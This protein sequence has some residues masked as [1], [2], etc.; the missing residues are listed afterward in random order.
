MIFSYPLFSSP[1]ELEEEKISVLIIENKA[2]FRR[3][4]HDL[5]LQSSG[6]EG[7]CLFFDNDKE[8][9]ISKSAE[10]IIDFFHI[11]INQTKNLTKLYTA[12]K[13][14]YMGGE[15]YGKYLD[16]SSNISSFM[17]ELIADFEYDLIYDEQVDLA[18]FFKAIG[19]KFSLEEKDF[20]ERLMDYLLLLSKYFQIKIFIL[21]NLKS[22]LTDDELANF[23]KFLFYNKIVVL[24]IESQLKSK[25]GD[26]KVRIIDQDLCII[27]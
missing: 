17:T 25:N 18:Q 27:D 13:S 5:F 1:F 3:I 15:N 7:E 23:Y 2:Y 10:I 9:K 6:L 26:E 16:L 14:D 19:L 21:V 24:L 12:L 22:L 20:L 4:L 11:D 8:L